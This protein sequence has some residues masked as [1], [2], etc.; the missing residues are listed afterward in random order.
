LLHGIEV[1]WNNEKVILQERL[2]ADIDD[3]L[4]EAEG[5]LEIFRVILQV[6]NLIW[7]LTLGHWAHDPSLSFWNILD[8]HQGTVFPINLVLEHPFFDLLDDFS[9]VCETKLLQMTY[10]MGKER[11][12]SCSLQIVT[13]C[14]FLCKFPIPN[15]LFQMINRNTY[16]YSYMRFISIYSNHTGTNFIT[17]K[18]NCCIYKGRSQLILLTDLSL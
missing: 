9:N 11:E 8:S 16:N 18:R 2:P 12:V 4:K 17:Q 5:A 7:T 14:C 13:V 6:S 3:M 1:V 10:G 15:V